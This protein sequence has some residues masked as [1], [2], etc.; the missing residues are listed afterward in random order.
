MKAFRSRNIEAFIHGRDIGF[1]VRTPGARVSLVEFLD[2]LT[3]ATSTDTGLANL[4]EEFRSAKMK[5]QK[6]KAEAKLAAAQAVAQGAADRA[7]RAQ[8]IA[9]GSRPGVVSGVS[10]PSISVSPPDDSDPTNGEGTS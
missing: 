6:A 8:A 9:S 7:K 3:D 5:G 1:T 10:S 4:I 2:W